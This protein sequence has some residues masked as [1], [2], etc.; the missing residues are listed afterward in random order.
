MIISHRHRYLFVEVPRTGST[1]ISAE[2]EKH[3]E[4][5]RILTKHAYYSTFLRQANEDEKKYL[6]IWGV[7]NPLD[8]A[9]SRYRKLSTKEPSYYAGDRRNLRRQVYIRENT[10]TFS[11]F[12]D[13][14]H[15]WP[16]DIWTKTYD[17]KSD[18]IIRFES[19]Q[20]DFA[21]ATE[22][23]GAELVRPLP[24]VNKT[25]RHADF[26]SYYSPSDVAKAVKIFGP[27]MRE[28]GYDFPEEWGKKEIP[29][30]SLTVYKLLQPPRRL[31]WKH[32]R[33]GDWF[34]ARLFRK[35]FLE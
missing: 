17:P 21:K 1:A 33:Q 26:E 7:R 14:F 15:R 19:L 9:V 16:F 34:G 2:L 27:Y 20:S 30:T 32:L 4:G 10:A 11:D 23:F 25:D 8:D 28:W 35:L 22:R 18:V 6:V 13:K 12:L 29:V 3:Y 5:E 31:Y 24:V